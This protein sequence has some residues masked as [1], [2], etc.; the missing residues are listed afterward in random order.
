MTEK[1]KQ[2]CAICKVDEFSGRQSAAIRHIELFVENIVKKFRR[3]NSDNFTIQLN[4]LNPFVDATDEI[5]SYLL[6][7]LE[8]L[9]FSLVVRGSNKHIDKIDIIC[10]NNSKIETYNYQYQIQNLPSIIELSSRTVIP[11]VGIIIMKIVAQTIV[12]HKVLYKAFV[13]DLDDTLWCGTLAEEGVEKIKENMQS[14]FGAPF[15]EFMN[16]VKVLA[17]E[18]GVFIAICSRNES[19]LVKS[20]IEQLDESVFPL[21]NQIDCIIANYNDKSGNIKDIAK[22]LSV[23]PDAVIFVDDNQIVR[24]EV[25]GKLPDVFVPEWTNHRELATQLISGCFFE[26]NE[27]SLN[28]QERRKQFEMIEAERLRNSLPKLLIKVFNDRDHSESKRLYAKSNQF[29]FSHHNACGG[30]EKS[31]YFELYRESGESLGICSA[32]TFSHLD[33]GFRIH[34]WAISCRYFEIGLEEFILIHLHETLNASTIRFDFQET[35]FNN[36]VKDLVGKYPNALIMCKDGLEMTYSKE[37][38]D[39][40]YKN[41]NIRKNE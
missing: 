30:K 9:G 1:Q 16:F 17:S 40:L 27:L 19:I 21:K 39:E 2:T 34:N 18:L 7:Q 28:S 36:K 13:F 15:V 4:G 35:E 22:R 26:R 32:M 31:I 38:I 5:T 41:T 3:Y 24:D 8:G 23:L 25:R 11:L 20:A 12:K 14:D 6:N 29:K 10:T 37:I 33:D